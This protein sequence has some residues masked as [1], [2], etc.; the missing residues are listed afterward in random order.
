MPG[1]HDQPDWYC[2]EVLPGRVPVEVVAE[3][4][5]SLAFRRP[6]VATG[7][8]RVLVIPRAHVRSLLELDPQES[9]PLLRMVQHVARLLTEVHGGCQVITNCGDAQHNRHLHWHVVAGPGACDI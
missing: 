1:V 3:D 5:H 6:S 2:D 8:D 4:K 9:V 7:R